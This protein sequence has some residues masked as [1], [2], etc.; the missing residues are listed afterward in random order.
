MRLNEK[1]K[2]KTEGQQEFKEANKRGRE[3]GF[4]VGSSFS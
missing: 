2:V 3:G 1:V 4:K